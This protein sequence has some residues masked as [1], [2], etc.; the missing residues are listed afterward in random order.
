MARFVLARTVKIPAG[1]PIATPASAPITLPQYVIEAIEITIPPGPNGLMGFRL[2]NA[3][4][5]VIPYG[6]NDWI[7]GNN[8]IKEW[9]LSNQITSGS[10]GVTGYNTGTYDHSIYLNF[11]VSPVDLTGAV[12]QAAQIAEVSGLTSGGG[13]GE[14]I[15][16]T[17]PGE[18]VPLPTLVL[19]NPPPVGGFT[20]PPPGPPPGG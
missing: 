13:G 18:Q 8:Q 7:I 4:Q 19:I 16:A 5:Q 17:I 6:S 1:T 9:P 10:W 20:P 14:T 3:G 15:T 11:L 2:T 12:D